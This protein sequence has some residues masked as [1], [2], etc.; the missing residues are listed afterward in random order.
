[1]ELDD[2]LDDLN[3][4]NNPVNVNH[5]IRGSLRYFLN[6]LINKVEQIPA[7]IEF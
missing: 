7:E 1:M 5:S 4:A 6:P 2:V 3:L